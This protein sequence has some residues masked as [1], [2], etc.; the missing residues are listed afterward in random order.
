MEYRTNIKKYKKVRIVC[1][2][3]DLRLG[4]GLPYGSLNANNKK[5]LKKLSLEN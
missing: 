5:N 2:L 1:L 4:L 3:L